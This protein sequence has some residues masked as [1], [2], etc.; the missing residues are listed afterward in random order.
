MDAKVSQPFEFTF[1]VFKV[2]GMWQ[3]GNQSWK[4]FVYGYSLH[5]VFLVLYLLCQIKYAINAVGLN[6][7]VETI[8]LAAT[9]AAEILKCWNF[10]IRINFI[11]KSYEGIKDLM[12][13]SDYPGA[14]NRERVIRP[15]R[16]AFKILKVFWFTAVLTCS[17]GILVPIFTHKVPYKVWFPF[18][19]EYGGNGFWIASI[20]LVLNS[21]VVS[22]ID[23]N[24]DCFPALFMS[25]ATGMIDELCHRM[26][27]FST[28]KELNERERQKQQEKELVKCIEV[29]KRIKGFVKEIQDNFAVI[30]LLQGEASAGESSFKFEFFLH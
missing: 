11:V 7:L 10:F 25:F 16:K 26:E 17:T 1:R 14:G 5:F 18:D 24:L 27:N 21:Y 4:Y 6:D 22:A 8:S 29:H 3:D 15:V 9:Y 28:D 30:I 12:E 13:N 20:Y 2:T 19:T 23:M